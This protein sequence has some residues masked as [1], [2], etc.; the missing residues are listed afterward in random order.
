ML[1][2]PADTSTDSKLPRWLEIELQIFVYGR[3]VCCHG[4]GEGGQVLGE[5]GSL[6]TGDYN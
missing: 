4:M 5:G 3:E 2:L 1:V 6:A